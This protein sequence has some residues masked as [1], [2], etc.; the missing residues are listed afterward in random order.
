MDRRGKDFHLRPGVFAALTR[1]VVLG[2][3]R[4]GS[5]VGY[6]LLSGRWGAAICHWGRQSEL[7]GRERRSNEQA[8]MQRRKRPRNGP[9]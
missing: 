2:R 1:I 7:L 4:H 9:R 8:G 5:D 3:W 6:Q